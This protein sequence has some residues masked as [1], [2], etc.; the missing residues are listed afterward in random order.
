MLYVKGY[1][2]RGGAGGGGFAVQFSRVLFVVYIARQT[3]G[4]N[5]AI[6]IYI[7]KYTYIKKTL[8]K[9]PLYIIIC[10]FYLHELF[11]LLKIPYF[12]LYKKQ[13]AYVF[14]SHLF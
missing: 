12:M 11:D 2:F 6:Y 14:S 10:L 9:R 13:S 7:Y 5:S 8:G 4:N 1:K 3:V